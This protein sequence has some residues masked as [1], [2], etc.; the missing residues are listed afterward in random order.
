[1][2]GDIPAGTTV[3]SVNDLQHLIETYNITE[4]FLVTTDFTAVSTCTQNL[5]EISLVHSKN[6]WYSTSTTLPRTINLKDIAFIAVESDYK[7]HQIALFDGTD[8]QQHLS[9]YERIK[10]DFTLVGS[11]ARDEQRISKYSRES[12]TFRYQVRADSVLVIFTSGRERKLSQ[13]EFLESLT[14]HKTHWTMESD[15]LT[16][17]WEN[18]PT[19]SIYDIYPLLNSQSLAKEPMLLIF[20]DG[21]GYNML[22]NARVL[23]RAGSFRYFEFQPM[24]TV[25]PP[26]T[27]YAYFAVGNGKHLNEARRLPHA[28]RRG[29]FTLFSDLN[30][31]SAYIIEGDRVFFTSRFPIVLNTDRNNNGCIDDEIFASAV[32]HLDKEFELLLVHFHSIDNTAHEHGPYAERTLQQIETVSRY[33]QELKSKWGRNT[34]VFSDHGLHSSGFSGRHGTNRIEDMV[35]IMSS[36][37]MEN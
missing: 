19:S 27:R 18:F 11:S 32:Q 2:Y 30:I 23:G 28:Q 21:L 31:S 22:E 33:V 35:A 15:T 36:L 24:R 10:R 12:F 8:R 9:A 16:I 17:V 5:S 4:L 6:V 37:V 14:F 20:V 13:Q 3:S 25:F 26:K 34:I 29:I 1:V 7:R